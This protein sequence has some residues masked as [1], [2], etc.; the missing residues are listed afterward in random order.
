MRF[1]ATPARLAHLSAFQVNIRL[2]AGMLACLFFFTACQQKQH[3][4]LFEAYFLPY[5]DIIS[6]RGAV[7]SA[8]PVL[9][10]AMT[11]Y[12]RQAYEE[13][14]AQFLQAGPT[15]P[16][17]LAIPFYL[18]VSYLAVNKPKIAAKHFEQVREQQDIIFGPHADWYLALAYLKAGES[19]KL[20]PLLEEINRSDSRYQDA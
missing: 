8:A 1:P 6:K 3:E 5:K 13:A 4:Q 14:I 9:L 2:A 16:Q 11:A 7:A 12:N 10:N 19:Q 15:D 17:N 20:V 18:G